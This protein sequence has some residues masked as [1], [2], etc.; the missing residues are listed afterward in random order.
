L[1]LEFR[2]PLSW[3][4][5]MPALTELRERRKENSLIAIARSPASSH[6]A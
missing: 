4:L 6:Y 2:N 3:Q 1:V 5:E